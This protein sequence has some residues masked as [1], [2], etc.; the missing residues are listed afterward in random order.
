LSRSRRRQVV[1]VDELEWREELVL[2][3]A[4]DRTLTGRRLFRAVTAR[5]LA[6]NAIGAAVAMVYLGFVAPPQPP[7]PETDFFHGLFHTVG[8]VPVYFLLAVLV[9]R[10]ASRHSSRQVERW[11]AE[12]RPP[13]SDER[14]L[15]LS[16]PWRAAVLTGVAW[17]L[18]SLVFG[19][20][21]ATHHPA[22]YVAGVV[23][24]IL[25]AGLTTT[26]ITFLLVERALRPLF[27][28]ALADATSSSPAGSV[29]ARSLGTAPR[30]LV[31]W[32]LGS[33]VALIA[34]AVAFLGR[35]DSRGDELIVPVL[36]LVVA[37]LFAGGVL[38]FA[39]GRSIHDPVDR[40]R[41]AVQRV[42][43]GSLDEHVVVDDGGEIGFL[44]A[45]FNRMVAG[46]R[47][48]ERIRAA[49]GTY[50]DSEVAEHIL[51]EGTNLAGEEVEVTA[52]FVDVRGFS[53]LA[54]R[55]SAAEV[56]AT[57]NR[58]FERAVPIIRAHGG[59]VDKFV[60]DGLL[61][62]FGAPRRQIDHAD[63]ALAAALDIER[64]VAEEFGGELAIGIGLNS[65][66]VV[67][68]NV[69]GAGRFEF[70]VI[71]DAVNV[72]A[73]V[74][75]ATR[76]T[77]DTVLVS[78]HTRALLSDRAAT[79]LEERP[80]VPLK[81]KTEEVALFAPVVGARTGPAAGSS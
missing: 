52:A 29:A 17:L 39:A 21:T 63:Q 80:A 23:V 42:G 46:L 54:E 61:A 34:I 11:L 66:R 65:G 40:V 78:E 8:T 22:V 16:L 18:A 81:G 12:D 64:A 2:T 47:E 37:G 70:S 41:A 56:V 51:R 3:D 45:G 32:A 36:F 35:G 10:H 26:G 74:E 72:A 76:E 59:H 55:A 4:G 75:A 28:L 53:G 48:R 62:V 30:M 49:F 6:A 73:R 13:G 25:L 60:G 24:G 5:A 38:T 67:A 19:V 1:G 31:S 71:G 14:A 79:A 44:Q 77:G 69:G 27:A 58:L 33:G 50:V 7:P 43:E 68:G 20:Q 9:S 15:V 57:L